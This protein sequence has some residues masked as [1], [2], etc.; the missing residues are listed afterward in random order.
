MNELEQSYIKKSRE[1]HRI[2]L[3]W[4]STR[5]AI[6]EAYMGHHHPDVDCEVEVKQEHVLSLEM[7]FPA[8]PKDQSDR[9]AHEVYAY[10]EGLSR[11][12][13]ERVGPYTVTHEVHTGKAKPSE[14]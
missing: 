10:L 8:Q 4:A 14:G 9:I 7:V 3:E 6:I 5:K 12:T 13:N 11:N 2:A 1:L